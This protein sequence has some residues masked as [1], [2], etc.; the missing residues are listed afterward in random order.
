MHTLADLI[1]SSGLTTMNAP[2]F[3]VHCRCKGLFQVD[4]AFL[5]HL[6]SFSLFTHLFRV[7][8]L[9]VGLTVDAISSV[10]VLVHILVSI[11]L[12]QNIECSFQKICIHINGPFR[13]VR[14][15]C[16][17]HFEH[18]LIGSLWAGEKHPTRV[19]KAF[20]RCTK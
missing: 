19:Y 2:D 12:Q 4:L 13:H 7:F 1:R 17:W 15:L 8:S 10:F 5:L 11:L 20:L 16:C 9:L 14:V 6:C 3:S 18:Y